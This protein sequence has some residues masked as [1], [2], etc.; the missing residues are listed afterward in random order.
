MRHRNDSRLISIIR[1]PIQGLTQ[2]LCCVFFLSYDD[3]F[4][5]SLDVLRYG[6]CIQNKM[7]RLPCTLPAA[8]V[9]CVTLPLN[10]KLSSLK[11]FLCLQR[12]PISCLLLIFSLSDLKMHIFSLMHKS[13][14]LFPGTYLWH[15]LTI[16]HFISGAGF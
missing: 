2:S 11:L 6:K 16:F 8:I 15:F 7:R 3:I 5:R 10:F 4:S 14:V 13:H 9:I 12:L 1:P